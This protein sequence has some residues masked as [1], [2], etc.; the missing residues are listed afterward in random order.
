MPK[1]QSKQQRK[2][3]YD[4]SPNPKGLNIGYIE[5]VSPL[6]DEPANQSVT[7]KL[8]ITMH[9][10]VLTGKLNLHEALDL[11]T[12]RYGPFPGQIKLEPGQRL[13]ER[14]FYRPGVAPTKK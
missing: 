5:R 6:H 12:P 8:G 13:E 7:D 9:G 1:Q 2:Q 14:Y 10:P 3:Q 4:V 11:P